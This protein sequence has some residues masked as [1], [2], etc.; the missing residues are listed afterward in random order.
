VPSLYI[1]DLLFF[2]MN[3]CPQLIGALIGLDFR[4]GTNLPPAVIHVCCSGKTI[5]FSRKI[6]CILRLKSI[7]HF[8]DLIHSSKST[9]PNALGASITTSLDQHPDYP[10]QQARA[11]P[12]HQ[13]HEPQ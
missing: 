10:K 8:T 5:D 1:L 13:P 9:E 4:Q 2:Y 7:A 3:E 12:R 6:S 11:M